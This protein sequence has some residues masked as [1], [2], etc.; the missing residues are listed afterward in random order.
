MKTLP[1]YELALLAVFGGIALAC[2]AVFA[3]EGW[4]LFWK[5]YDDRMQNGRR[6]ANAQIDR[7]YRTGQFYIP[8]AFRDFKGITKL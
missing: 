1:L 3:F 2:L 4:H 7:A 8:S 5:W 6:I